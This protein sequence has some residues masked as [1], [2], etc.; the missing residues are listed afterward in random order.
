V[1]F[2]IADA[3]LEQM[4]VRCLG[5]ASQ[6]IFKMQLDSV[7]PPVIECLIH[8]VSMVRFQR[9]WIASVRYSVLASEVCGVLAAFVAVAAKK[10]FGD[11]THDSTCFQTASR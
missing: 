5:L 10:D 9:P 11:I 1:I 3:T 8:W 4:G 7:K 2:E 6:V